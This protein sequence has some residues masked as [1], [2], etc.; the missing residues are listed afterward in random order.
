MQNESKMKKSIFII[1]MLLLSRNKCKTCKAI[2]VQ[3]EYA[4]LIRRNA[5]YN[6][7]SERLSAICSDVRDYA[8]DK[9]CEL[10]FTNPPYMK[11][12]SGRQNSNTK[13]TVARHEVFGDIS[14]FARA[15]ARL[16][17]YGGAFYAVYRPDRLIDIIAAMRENSLEP[18]RMTFVLASAVSEASMVLIEAKKGARPGLKLTRPLII[19]KDAMHKEYSED[20]NYIMESGRFPE[21]FGK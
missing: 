3:E 14:D 4:E 17:K 5:E 1:S 11:L 12:T 21:D 10:V 9:E 8:P 18:K 19:Y 7:L 13:K 6:S 16:L 2:E 20:M 15:G